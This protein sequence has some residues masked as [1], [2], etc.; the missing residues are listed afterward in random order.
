VEREERVEGG[1][2]T[3]GEGEGIT[4]IPNR[5][6]KISDMKAKEKAVGR[7]TGAS[8]KADVVVP[9]EKSGGDTVYILKTDCATFLL[10]PFAGEDFLLDQE[11]HPWCGDVDTHRT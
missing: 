11:V 8:V 5:R 9:K 4:Q 6:R 3:T 2:E 7:R 1:R 10:H